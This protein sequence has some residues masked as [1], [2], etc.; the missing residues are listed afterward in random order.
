MEYIVKNFTRFMKSE[1]EKSKHESK[2]KMNE[3]KKIKVPTIGDHLQRKNMWLHGGELHTHKDEHLK[4]E[5]FSSYIGSSGV[6][7]IFS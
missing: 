1:K 2:K 5:G 4:K 7:F 6:K 3:P